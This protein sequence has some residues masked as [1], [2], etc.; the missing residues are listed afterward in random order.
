MCLHGSEQLDPQVPPLEAIGLAKDKMTF[1]CLQKTT[2]KN[3]SYN[4][5]VAEF[6]EIIPFNRGFFESDLIFS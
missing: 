1:N 2:R 6:E 5:L 4:L 3:D